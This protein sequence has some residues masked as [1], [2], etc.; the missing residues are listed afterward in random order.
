MGK[1]VR[2][3]VAPYDPLA[4]ELS[5]DTASEPAADAMFPSDAAVDVKDGHYC[6]LSID[7]LP[8]HL[9]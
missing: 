3:E 5:D 9:R 2:T 6:L 4:V 7:L 1:W 8:R